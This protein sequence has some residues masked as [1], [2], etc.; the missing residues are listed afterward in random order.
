MN[1]VALIKP[2]L[3]VLY[4]GQSLTKAE[5]WK[6]AQALTNLGIAMVAIVATFVPTVNLPSE[7]IGSIAV[8]IASVANW[9]LTLATSKT[10]GLPPI[11]LQAKP[12]D[13]TPIKPVSTTPAERGVPTAS[14]QTTS[15][16]ATDLHSE[17]PA[18]TLPEGFFNDSFGD[19]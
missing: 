15:A 12:D 2:A 19:K 16:S 9:Y 13:S 18:A 8:A 10:V 1:I 4:H 7:T 5:T 17:R 11:E 14:V 6:N 3:T